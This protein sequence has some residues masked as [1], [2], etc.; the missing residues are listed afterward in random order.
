MVCCPC[1]EIILPSNNIIKFRKIKFYFL[2]V[3]DAREQSWEQ[4]VFLDDGLETW[5]KAESKFEDLHLKGRLTQKLQFKS[6][7][8]FEIVLIHSLLRH[9]FIN[10]QNLKKK[11]H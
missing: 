11:M 6:T 4:T 5:C 8:S 3:K 1:F 2:R 10:K 9:G 7:F